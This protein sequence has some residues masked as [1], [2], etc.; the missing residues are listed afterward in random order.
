MKLKEHGRSKFQDIVGEVFK[1]INF[2]RG[3]RK[4]TTRHM[5]VV[6]MHKTELSDLE[7][8]IKKQIK[9]LQSKKKSLT[10]ITK[11]KV[12][13][14]SIDKAI[15]TARISLKDKETDVDKL[16]EQKAF[17][18]EKIKDLEPIDDDYIVYSIQ[19][20]LDHVSQLKEVDLNQKNKLL[21]Y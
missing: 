6:E 18:E 10:N 11:L 8:Q 3:K 12:E 15:K 20:I 2:K 17:L 7:N 1:E 9:E 16:T 14:D 5:K 4:S 19:A 13:L 21:H